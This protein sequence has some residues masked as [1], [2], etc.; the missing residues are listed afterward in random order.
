M[1]TSLTVLYPWPSTINL[2][3]TV[4]AGAIS[5]EGGTV[6]AKCAPLLSFLRAAA[7]EGSA[8][9]FA[10]ADLEFVALDKALEAQRT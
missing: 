8:I 6:K 2:C 10:M 1:C 7:V 3:L 4:L 5:S 9:P